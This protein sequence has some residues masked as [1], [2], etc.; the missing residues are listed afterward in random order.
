MTG[1]S[2]ALCLTLGILLLAASAALLLHN[3]QEVRQAQRSAE[4]LLAQTCA[5]ETDAAG[6]EQAAQEAQPEEL[7]AVLSVPALALELPVLPAWSEAELTRAPCR[8]QGSAEEGG[9]VIAGHNYASHFGSLSHLSTGDAVTLSAADGAV[10]RYA[11][12]RVEQVAA[13]DTDTVL[14]AVEPLVLYTCTYGG[15]ARIAVFCIRDQD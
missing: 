12:A 4:L 6:Q 10:Y 3:R 14:A 13:D 1:R 9:L 5:A 2:S 8:Q 11:V 7:F 15:Q